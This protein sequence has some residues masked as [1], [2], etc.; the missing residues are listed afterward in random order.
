M[1]MRLPTALKELQEN[2]EAITCVVLRDGKEVTLTR[3]E[4]L[5]VAAK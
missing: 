4:K 3:T 2:G 1:G 5:P